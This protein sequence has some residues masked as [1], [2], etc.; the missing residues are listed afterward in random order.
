[1]TMTHQESQ[2][3]A[4]TTPTASPGWRCLTAADLDAL[5]ASY[6]RLPLTLNGQ[7]GLQVRFVRNAGGRVVAVDV[8]PAAPLS[9]GSESRP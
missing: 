7:P 8:S 9:A 1:M 4:T 3:F 5:V 6:G 2:S